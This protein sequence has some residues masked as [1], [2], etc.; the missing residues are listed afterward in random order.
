MLQENAGLSLGDS[1][2]S[3]IK[4][5]G[6]IELSD[7][8]PVVTLHVV[9]IDFEHRLRIGMGL[10]G[11]ADIGV[12]LLRGRLLGSRAHKHFSR[13][14]ADAFSVEH[15]FIK[16]VGRTARRLMV[17]E[18]IIIHAL[19]A[20]CHHSAIGHDRRAFTHQTEIHGVSGGTT[21]EHHAVAAH[22]AILLQFCIQIGETHD[23]IGSFFNI[24]EA[25]FCHFIGKHL[26]HL[27]RQSRHA[28]RGVVAK[29]NRSLGS[30]SSHHQKATV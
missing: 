26:H 23:I 7:A 22:T 18:D 8:R 13:I 24:V 9:G 12:H 30:L 2:L 21:G 27:R 29:Q 5:R 15:I 25:D 28:W 16:E 1:A 3:H 20:V 14:G 17:N 11:G 10:R 4:K 6:F 19:L